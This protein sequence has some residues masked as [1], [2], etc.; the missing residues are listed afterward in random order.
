MSYNSSYSAT[1]PLKGREGAFRIFKALITR[2]H[3]VR[4][5][6]AGVRKEKDTFV[7]CYILFIIGVGGVLAEPEFLQ[8]RKRR[9]AESSTGM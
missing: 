2:N 1:S 4:N 8:W 9:F 7:C 6:C 5:I 3:T